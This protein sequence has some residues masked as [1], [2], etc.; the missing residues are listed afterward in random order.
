[1]P[2]EPTTLTAPADLVPQLRILLPNR[3]L[4]YGQALVTADRQ[5]LRT[6]RL[7]GSKTAAVDFSWMF[8]HPDLAVELRPEYK[9][10][11]HVS[12]ITTKINGELVTFINGNDSYLRQR[13]TLAHEFKH[14]LDFE[15]VDSAYQKLG[16]GNNRL[17]EELVERICNRF[18][19][20][21][22]MPKV[23]L[24]RLWSRGITDPVALAEVFQV[25]NEAM[26][27]R[28]EQLGYLGFTARPHSKFFRQVDWPTIPKSTAP[29]PDEPDSC[30]VA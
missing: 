17:H 27:I 19:A 16:R 1:M 22:L 21:L 14:V 8:D 29:A 25:S 10:P 2:D 15:A 26:M 11:D 30:P 12:G 7:L 28:L 23:W 6:R 18:A 20:A 13:F 4:T 24:N 5:A 9:M 3:P